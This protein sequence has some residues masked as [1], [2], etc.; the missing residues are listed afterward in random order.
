MS[1]RGKL[2]FTDVQELKHRID[3]YFLSRWETRQM[4]TKGADGVWVEWEEKYQRPPTMAG[5]ALALDTTRVTLMHYGKG[6]GTRDNGFISII[7][8]AKTQIAEYAEEALYVRDAS[9]GAKFALEVNHGY[10]RDEGE[11]G[12]GEGFNV[13][14]I[15][16][17]S[18]EQLTAIPKWQPEEADDA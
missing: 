17:A 12:T 16:P 11:G 3:E 8:R 5:L 1:E 9:N 4:K 7:A 14:V 10:G 15:P 13:R 6:E 18:S 2:A